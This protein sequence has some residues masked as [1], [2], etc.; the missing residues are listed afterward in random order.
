MIAP[1]RL[2][3]GATVRDGSVTFSV[4]APHATRA[5][6]R[7][8]SGPRAGDHPLD[9]RTDGVCELV[10]HDAP[11]GTDYWYVLDGVACPD[12][13]SR[14]QPAGVHGASRVV[15][16]NDFAWTDAAWQGR[17]LR[18][19]VVYELHVGSFTSAGT[20]DGVAEQLDRLVEL[21]V[22]AIELMP[23][24]EFPG[25]RNWGYDGVSPYAPQSTYGGPGGLRRLVD[26]AHRANL[27]VILDVVYN[28][29]G[30]EG[31][32]LS[33]FGPYFTDRYRT[34]WG[35]SFNFDGADSDEVRRYVLDNARYWV[36][37]FHVDGLRL[38]AVHAIY[39]FSAQHVLAELADAVHEVAAALGRRVLVVA[40]SDLNDARLVR[41][42]SA[43]GYGLDGQWCDDFHHALHVALTG[44]RDGY[45]VDFDGTRSVAKAVR[46]RFVLDGARS[47][48]RRR[49]HGGVATDV[50]ADRFVVFAQNHDQVGNRALGERLGALVPRPAQ[51]LAAAL[52]CLSPYVPL[53]FMGEEYGEPNPFLY[54]VSH[55]DPDLAE[56]VREG[57]RREFADFTWGGTIPDP[58]VEETFRRSCLTR[59]D[60]PPHEELF[61]LYRDL[62]RARR[63]EGALRPGAATVTAT[64]D[65]DEAWLTVRLDGPAGRPL[66]SAFNLAAEP[67]RFAVSDAGTGE[68]GLLLSTEDVVYGGA[69]GV[70]TR[71]PFPE[72]GATVKLQLPPHAAA[73]Y[74]WEPS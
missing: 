56:A 29:L 37:E 67:R 58:T 43:G 10:V 9:R 42:S 69:G 46:D 3:R 63:E 26:A 60:D 68:W 40:E 61:R 19:L 66:L 48:Y 32:Y 65:P 23:V 53:L 6:V 16:P 1:W 44:E 71:I 12:P 2:D 8:A 5:A 49:R 59:P 57:R 52:V 7:I 11:A 64:C 25:G 30:P 21:G 24:A 62:L 33:R 31:N 18:D 15:D 41:E 35:E 14:S 22:T 73:L 17:E 70:P 4:W 50:P 74:R 38:D 28:H 34:P 54:F 55:S 27:A 20:F 45:Y 36:T 39:D 72:D 13:V 51:R 47:V